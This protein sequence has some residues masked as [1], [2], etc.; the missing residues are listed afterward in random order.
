VDSNASD[1]KAIACVTLSS[2]RDERGGQMRGEVKKVLAGGE[3]EGGVC[4]SAHTE[5][6]QAHTA[7]W[8]WL[9]VQFWSWIWL[10]SRLSFF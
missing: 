10:V 6:H 7:R 8:R 9:A 2:M 5:Q 1:R 4:G 3:E